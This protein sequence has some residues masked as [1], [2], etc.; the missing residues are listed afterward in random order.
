M[1]S[2]GTATF[3]C[4]TDSQRNTVLLDKLLTTKYPLGVVLMELA[5]QASLRGAVLRARWLP[6]LR[7][8]EADALT[9]SEFGHFEMAN[10]IDVG[11]TTLPFVVLSSSPMATRLSPTRANGMVAGLGAASQAATSM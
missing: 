6:R 9:N 1:E 3:S 7:N 10:R 2:V 11:L 8:Q 5:C 4:D